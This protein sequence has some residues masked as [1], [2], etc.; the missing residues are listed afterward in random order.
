MLD[1]TLLSWLSVAAGG[2]LF[3][4]S[5]R[6]NKWQIDLLRDVF[7]E[8]DTNLPIVGDVNLSYAAKSSLI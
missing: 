5:S 4:L 1:W 7:T 3:W 8:A 6:E 2:V